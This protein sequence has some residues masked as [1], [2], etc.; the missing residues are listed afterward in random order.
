MDELEK[1]ANTLG[2]GKYQRHIFLCADQTEFQVLR[3]GNWLGVVE[4]F[5]KPTEGAR[6]CGRGA[7]GISHQGKLPSRVPSRAGG[8]GVSGGH[9]VPLLHARSVGAHHS[10][11]PY[12]RA[13]CKRSCLC[14]RK[15]LPSGLNISAAF[16]V[17]DD[18]LVVLVGSKGDAQKFGGIDILLTEELAVAASAVHEVGW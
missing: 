17:I 12:Q 1:T 14:E 11:A 10:G 4:F 6:P 16:H 9:L 8:G 15:W 2:L 18:L 5:K 7:K 3:Q 13:H